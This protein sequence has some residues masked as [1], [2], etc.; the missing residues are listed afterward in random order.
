M[1]LELNGLSYVKA[2]IYDINGREIATLIDGEFDAGYKTINWNANN[3]SSGI[4][5][6]NIEVNGKV[7]SNQKISLIK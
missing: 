3:Q 4:Y 5:F 2:L 1:D 7:V 6:I